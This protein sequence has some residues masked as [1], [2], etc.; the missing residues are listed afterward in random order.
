M[1][2]SV[3]SHAILWMSH[4]DV[5]WTSLFSSV[6]RRKKLLAPS[7]H[8]PF[9]LRTMNNWGRTR[10]CS[11]WTHGPTFP[12]R[13]P[14]H[15]QVSGKILRNIKKSLSLWHSLQ[16]SCFLHNGLSLTPKRKVTPARGFETRF[17]ADRCCPPQDG[18]FGGQRTLAGRGDT[19][20]LP[21]ME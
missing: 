17:I 3:L 7:H 21:S 4:F 14:Q 11:Y 12:C 13:L 8:H 20:I 2:G 1:R 15:L 18:P 9:P 19:E 5:S 16:A 6:Y 10:T